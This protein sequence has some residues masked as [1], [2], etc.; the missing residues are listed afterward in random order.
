MDY[1]QKA[2][3]PEITALLGSFKKIQSKHLATNKT[4]VGGSSHES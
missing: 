4:M 2:T 3:D 1:L